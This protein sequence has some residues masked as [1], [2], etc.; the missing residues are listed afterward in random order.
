M[1]TQDL[2]EQQMKLEEEMRT[3]TEER[4]FRTHEKA[5]D[6]GEFSETH[7]GR[8][9]MS[10]VLDTFVEGIDA[11]CDEFRTGKAGRRPRAMHMIDQFGDTRK[12]AFIFVKQ[13]MNIVPMLERSGSDYEQVAKRTSVALMTT[14]GIHDELRIQHFMD[15]RKALL[16]AILKDF[17]KRDL[18][19]ERRRQLLQRTF[20][21]QQI[22]WVAEGWGQAERLNLGLVLLDVFRKSTGMIEE[23]SR[24][25]KNG[26]SVVSIVSIQI[27]PEFSAAMMDRMGKVA[28]MFTLFYPTVIP[29]KQWV[30]GELVGGGY[31]T[32]N[33]TPYR[34]IKNSKPKYMAEMENVDLSH[35]LTPLNAIQNTPWKINTKML[36]MLKHVFENSIDVTGL[37]T[38]DHKE[39]PE[40]PLG[41][42]EEG[43]EDILK[44]YK[45]TCYM[46]HDDNRRNVSKR[47]AVIRTITLAEKFAEYEAIYFPH[48][49]DSRGRAYPRP[50]FLSPQG[51]DYAKGVL[52]F[53]E[54]KTIETEDDIMFLA[55][56]GANA[57]GQDKL[58]LHKRYE[59]VMDNQDLFLDIAEDPMGDLRWTKA[60]EPF[61]ALRFCLEWQ[62]LA[63][64]GVGVFKSSM[65]VHFDATCSGLQHFSALLRDREGGTHVNLT[66]SGKREDIYGEVARKAA[67]TITALLNDAEFGATA[68]IALD[69]GITRS[70]CKRPVM[71]VPYA[72]T[73]S[74]CMTYVNDYYREQ[75][76][77]GHALPL[78]LT[79]LRKTVTPF[80]A[81]HI[82]AAIS[83][84]V[85][86]AREAMD[87]ITA[88]AKLACSDT[89]STP[90]QWTTPDGFI[91]QQAKYKESERRI[92]TYLDG[93]RTIRSHLYTDTNILDARRNAQSLSP[94]YI[95]SMDACHMRKSISLALTADRN[96]SFAMIH[97]SFGCHASDMKWF[98][99]ECIKPAFVDMYEGG[100]NLELFKEQL[101]VN[102]PDDKRSKLRELPLKGSLDLSEVLQSEFF[103]S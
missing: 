17:K 32:E 2:L 43:N 45:K 90:L 11:W 65:P 47:L 60:D 76:D 28:N 15:N 86:A 84:T 33:V 92:K 101:M 75:A 41:F 44:E 49:I 52:E 93:E 29:P 48:D 71:I 66:N 74:S 10:H 18:N 99:A 80:V 64:Q 38:A 22:D 37:I 88:T 68:K 46:I 19:R 40:P 25:A 63:D 5:E 1:I 61:M 72:G 95:H 39:L 3:V 4:Y 12:L 9:V 24:W 79:E 7:T 27:N 103:F 58:P 59:W 83:D 97:D 67:A 94:N 50:T 16:Q 13:L 14:Q 55:I 96:L 36:E 30:N 35:V 78:E 62:G 53:A 54:G 102:I 100:E 42:K 82:W 6:R 77:E 26:K 91:V 81:K 56:A 57:W 31:Y 8:N 20:K 98:L 89:A 70:L 21:T 73:F 69:I 51:A 34:L 87:W 85:I 23:V